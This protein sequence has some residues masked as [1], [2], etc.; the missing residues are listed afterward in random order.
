ME[1][2]KKSRRM[3]IKFGR[4]LMAWGSMTLAVPA[5]FLL[6]ITFVGDLV[7]WL[8]KIV[9]TV[10]SAIVNVIL[11]ENVNL[12]DGLPFILWLGVGVTIAADL[13]ADLT[14]NRK[15]VYGAIIW[16]SLPLAMGGEWGANINAWSHD[17]NAWV[18]DTAGRLIGQTASF[19]I[20]AGLI[21]V[22]VILAQ[23]VLGDVRSTKPG[24]AKTVPAFAAAGKH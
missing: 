9:G 5:G 7:G 6:S 11:D 14:P 23:K 20:A 22:S 12:V 4:W 2:L 3:F 21:V 19:T 17:L 1:T 8:I 16:P 10:L 18:Q 13:L 15:A 24:P